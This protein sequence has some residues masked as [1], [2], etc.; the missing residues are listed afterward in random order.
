MLAPRRTPPCRIASVAVLN[1]SMNDTGP[2]AIPIVERTTSPEGRSRENEKPVPPPVCW[3]IAAHFTASKIS[4]IAS[5]TGTSI[6]LTT[7]VFAVGLDQDNIY[8]GTRWDDTA[9]LGG[10]VPYTTNPGLASDHPYVSGIAV[11]R[12]AQ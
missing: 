3:I 10:Q 7:G 1:T 11:P 5:P 12:L 4:G 9:N 2:D 8:D 6:F